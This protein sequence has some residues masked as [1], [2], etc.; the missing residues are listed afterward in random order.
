VDWPVSGLLTRAGRE[1]TQR[2]P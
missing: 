2:G 1:L